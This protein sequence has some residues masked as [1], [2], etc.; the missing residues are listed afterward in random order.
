[1]KKYARRLTALALALV[2]AISA[3]GQTAF[4]SIALGTEL[5]D[6]TVELAK[7]VSLTT[8]SLWS[9]SKSDLRTEH[10]ITYTPGSGVMPVIYSG[11]YVV[12]R[13]TV[14]AAASA[15]EGHGYRVIAGVNGGFF[16]GDG[17][18]VGMLMTEGVVRSLDVYNY[19]LLG[20]TNDG[21][22]FVDENP[23]TK[24]VAWETENGPKQY[25]LAGFNAY[26]SNDILGGLYLYN[27]DFGSRVNKDPSRDCVCVVLRPMSDEGVTAAMTMN[28]PVPFEVVSVADTGEDDAFNG[29][30][31]DGN[32]ML[33]AN[34]Y[35]GNEDL[36]NSLRA[37]EAGDQVTVT[38]SADSRWDEAAYA[39]TGLYTLLRGGEIVASGLSAAA[40]PY[41]AVGIR[42][43][44]AAVFYTIDGRQ[45]GYSVGATYAQVAE[46]LQEL[47][48]VTAVALDGGG[49]TNLG[50]T[51][52]GSSRF[53]ILNRPSEKG[54]AVN[55]SIFLVAG[56][57]YA[58]M[59]PGF[60][61]SSDTQVVLAGASLNVS[62]E[63]YDQWGEASSEKMPVWTATG[64]TVEGNGLTAVYTAGDAAGAYAVSAGSGSD[65]PVQVVDTL[66]S[67]RVT[68]EGSSA[69]VS[70]LNLKPGDTVDL[71]ASGVWWNLP[72]AMDD[73]DVVWEADASIGTI[74]ASGRFQATNENTG[75]SGKIT[76][77]A[78]D[79]TVTVGVTVQTDYPFT[80]IAGHWS[81]DYVR[82]LY[83]LG[84]TAGYAQPDGTAVF[85][86]DAEMTRGELLTFITRLL[87]V[88]TDKYQDVAL[89][90]ADANT[91]PN[92]MLPYVKAMYALGVLS[93]SGSGGK[94][95]ANVNDSVS[96]E[97]A[98][99]ML[100]RVL[101][102]QVSQDL[103]GFADSGSV[104]DWARPYMETLVGLNVVQ[105]SDG[106]LK[107]K[108]NI[109]RGEAAKLLVEIN[110]LKKAELTQRPPAAES[111]EPE[112]QTPVD[113]NGTFINPTQR[114]D[115]SGNK[116]NP[117]RPDDP[118]FDPLD[119]T[120]DWPMFDQ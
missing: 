3:M 59:D 62:A 40:H 78:G 49:S 80:D 97:E 72:V 6:R 106:K 101:A 104:S 17:T 110:G 61:L 12:S 22:V 85:K 88:D 79:K 7:G 9:A 93:G 73:S 105:G 67:L 71:T 34:Y 47:G 57:E 30:L 82:Q 75:A 53:T 24:T 65:L 35:N 5:V 25:N 48:C 26:R 83:D 13:N 100:G 107:P 68:R 114:P 46:R 56:D 38:V 66:S 108:S 33:Y 19:A 60:Y 86:P 21:K 117:V 14:A 95:Y 11:N 91:I 115:Q 37:M 118:F 113:P 99:T 45:S 90:F 70:S 10:Y 15:L 103:S 20:F 28:R 64:G 50:A 32:Y 112:A 81:A 4:A 36:L 87:N 74:D 8:Q 94:L 84:L 58:G 76:A 31:D 89:P 63:G 92:W 27:Q 55:N 16:N 39:I 44:G 98:M 41:T 116:N 52:P 54:R 109:K 96:R 51:L 1:M 42:E 29:V 18:V 119:W 77:S 43:D 102:D 23:L 120:V 111:G 2:L 69:A